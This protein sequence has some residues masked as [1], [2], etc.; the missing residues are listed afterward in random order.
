M[1][2]N[3]IFI[4]LM[5]SGSLQAG[6]Q[7]MLLLEQANKVKP[8][9]FYPGDVI[10]FQKN[11]D[12]YSTWYTERIRAIDV[13]KQ[14]IEIGSG[15]VPIS[16]IVAMRKARQGLAYLGRQGLQFGA[17][18]AFFSGIAIAL[19]QDAKQARKFAVGAGTI[20]LGSFIV[21]R[22]FKYK[23][24]KMGKKYRLRIV[25]VPVMPLKPSF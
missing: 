17:Q 18:A 13:E 3:M 20:V 22:V 10:T 19:D 2:K 9:K 21:S 25:E 15:T 23:K 6:A 16:D 11:E 8:K 7:K 5:L 24:R 4:S 1:I 12:G 14:E